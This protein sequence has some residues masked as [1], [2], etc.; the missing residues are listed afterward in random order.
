MFLFLLLT[1]LQHLISKGKN[2]ESKKFINSYF[3]YKYKPNNMH[4]THSVDYVFISL[5]FFIFYKLYWLVPKYLCPLFILVFYNGF[6]SHYYLLNKTTL[7]FQNAQLSPVLWVLT[8]LYVVYA[9]SPFSW[10][11][12]PLCT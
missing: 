12:F 3:R 6:F 1:F 8:S 9:N 5:L 2:R 7:Q 11:F 4:L 10:K